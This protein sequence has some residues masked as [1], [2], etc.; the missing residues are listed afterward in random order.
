MHSA[1]LYSNVQYSKGRPFPPHTFVFSFLILLYF[2]FG[3][4]SV[5]YPTIPRFNFLFTSLLYN[6]ITT[7]YKMHKIFRFRIFFSD[8]YFTFL[9]SIR[10]FLYFLQKTFLSLT[11]SS[12]R[13]NFSNIIIL[14]WTKTLISE[15]LSI[16]L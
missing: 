3:F 12:S 15:M 6:L 2:Y 11:L 5:F 16:T 10:R 13:L 7:L 1:V 9:I 4:Y 8:R 14:S